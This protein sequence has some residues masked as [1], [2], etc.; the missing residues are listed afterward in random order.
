LAAKDKVVEQVEEAKLF[1]Y[2]AFFSRNKWR[3]VAGVSLVL[4][5][6]IVVGLVQFLGKRKVEKAY[7]AYAKAMTAEEYRAVEARFPGTFYGARSLIEAGRSLLKDGKFAEARKLFLKLLSDY[8]E[9]RFRAWANIL[10]GATFEGEEKY[11]KA[12]SYYRKAEASR[13]LRLQAKLN[14]GRCYEFKGDSQKEAED[15]LNSYE[16]AK[17]Y[18]RQLTETGSS[19]TGSRRPPTA[20]QREA[21]TRMTFLSEKETRMRE[22]KIIDKGST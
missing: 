18:Y 17:S 2:A 15:R 16:L 22:E 7:E 10:V 9:S 14:M 4:G 6:L 21:R 11:D 5:V 20:W 19:S 13:W 8:E 3:I 1:R 12:I